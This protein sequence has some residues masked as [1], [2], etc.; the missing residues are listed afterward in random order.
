MRPIDKLTPEEREL[1]AG[2]YEA[3]KAGEPVTDA[4]RAAKALYEHFVRG[5][6]RESRKGHGRSIQQRLDDLSDKSGDCWTWTGNRDREGYGKLTVD[7]KTHRAH[8]LAAGDVPAGH[9]VHHTCGDPS[10]VNPEHLECLTPEMHRA[11]H[12]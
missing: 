1:R 9:E 4:Q 10:C 2:Y 8:R 6:T 11:R 12:S 5:G 7:G 3:R